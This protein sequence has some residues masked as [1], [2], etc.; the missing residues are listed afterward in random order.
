METGDGYGL[1]NHFSLK[2]TLTY[3]TIRKF[4]GGVGKVGQ[5]RPLYYPDSRI[6]IDQ[7]SSGE[8]NFKK[9]YLDR[10]YLKKTLTSKAIVGRPAAMPAPFLQ[11]VFVE[12]RSVWCCVCG[13]GGG[14]VFGSVI[15]G[16]RFQ[17]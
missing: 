5:F 9:F 12:C 4:W 8:L 14:G 10:I 15:L 7:S 16:L 2:Q 3:L 11:L 1:Q 6:K 13:G 17:D